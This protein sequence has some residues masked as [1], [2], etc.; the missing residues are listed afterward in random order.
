[1]A[2]L[3]RDRVKCTRPFTI[4]GVDFAGPIYIRSGLRRVAAK[5][6]WIAIF[7]CFSNKG[8]EE[9]VLS[10]SDNSTNFV[11]AQKELVS[12][13]K[14]ASDDL[15]KE[16]IE[17]HFNPPSAPHF[18]GI[19]ESAVKSMKHHL[20]RVISDYKLTS[21]E[22][23][24]L[25]CQIEACLNSR[26]MTPLNSDPSD[27]AVLTPS[28][29]LIGGAML[30]P[31]EPDITK[32]EP[33]GLRRWQLVQNLMQT[34]WKRWSK[35]YLPQIQIRGKWTSKSAQLAKGDVVI[36][37]DDCMPPTRWKLGLVVELHPGSDDDVMQD[38]V[39]EL[40]KK[41]GIIKASLTLMKNFV[42]RFDPTVDAISLLEFRQEELPR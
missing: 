8:Q 39:K 14:K 2:A 1:M 20:K 27:L 33:K 5:K 34:F 23:R 11:G 10:C 18:G 6:A 16:G 26:P 25:L 35:E 37:K 3:P 38:Q 30:L 19:W 40:R 28:H 21:T 22:M 12:M 42:E 32:E 36:I 4:T 15:E 7:V 31:E 24:T 13:M 29:F 9:N 17:W 41:R